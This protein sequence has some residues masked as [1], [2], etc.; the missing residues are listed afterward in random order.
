MAMPRWRLFRQHGG[1][2]PGA[3]TP[4]TLGGM[5]TAGPAGREREVFR[6]G[7]AWGAATRGRAAFILLT[8]DGDTCA[9]AAGLI[10]RAA[11]LAHRTGGRVTRMS[12]AD[13]AT[14]APTPD[15]DGRPALLVLEDLGRADAA[16]VTWLRGLMTDGRAGARVLVIATAR[17]DDIDGGAE[18][19]GLVDL[20]TRID[21]GR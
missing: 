3:I 13:A 15:A 4:N 1:V 16:T 9:D 20:V 10:D 5:T 18:V 6:L 21:L 2:M 14:T 12:C 8:A 7:A 17:P 19:S 11:A